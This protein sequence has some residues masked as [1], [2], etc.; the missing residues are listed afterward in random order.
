[1]SKFKVGDRI[2]DQNEIIGTIL[3][4]DKTFEI[5]IRRDDGNGHTATGS[6]ITDENSN[7]VDLDIKSDKWWVKETFAKFIDEE[8]K[9]KL[10]D[11]VV[12]KNKGMAKVKELKFDRTAEK[13]ETGIVTDIYLDY[14]EILLDS[15]SKYTTRRCEFLLK[16]SIESINEESKF[17][18]LL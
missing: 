4:F 1:M 10:G 17:K 8:N 12:N 13:G 2:K 16:E 15:D 11:R 9:F 3:G 18:F 7:K 14:I 6:P 5:L